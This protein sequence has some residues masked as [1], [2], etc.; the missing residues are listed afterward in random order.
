MGNKKTVLQE[1]SAIKTDFERGLVDAIRGDAKCFRDLIAVLTDMGSSQ[2]IVNECR[3]LSIALERS[4]QNI[5]RWSNE[6][7]DKQQ[8]LPFSDSW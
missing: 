4:A 8:K 6:S 2:R 1:Q 3:L 5:L 7:D